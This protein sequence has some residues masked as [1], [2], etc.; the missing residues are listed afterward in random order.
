MYDWIHELGHCLTLF[1]IYI[2]IY[3]YIKLHLCVSKTSWVSIGLKSTEKNITRLYNPGLFFLRN[4]FSKAGL[5]F[6]KI[7]SIWAWNVSYKFWFTSSP[8]NAYLQCAQLCLLF[9]SQVPSKLNL[10]FCRDGVY[11]WVWFC[12][13][14]LM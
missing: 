5:M 1:Y 12:V 7:S 10:F 2:Y 11:F 6:L 14:V 13:F 8:K 9:F 4:T 3:I